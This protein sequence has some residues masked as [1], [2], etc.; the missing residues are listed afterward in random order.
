MP[1]SF[2]RPDLGFPYAVTTLPGKGK[3]SVVGFGEIEQIKNSIKIMDVVSIFN[4]DRIIFEKSRIK[5]NL[6]GKL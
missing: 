2:D 5:S 6:D 1:S 3:G 4:V